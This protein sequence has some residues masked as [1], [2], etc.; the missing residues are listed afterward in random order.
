MWAQLVCV[1]NF[2]E[3]GFTCVYAWVYGKGLEIQAEHEK[4]VRRQMIQI[5]PNQ[6]IN[7]NR[8]TLYSTFSFRIVHKITCWLADMKHIN[9]EL[10]WVRMNI[11]WKAKIN[12][13][14]SLLCAKTFDCS[15]LFIELNAQFATQLL[16]PQSR[17]LNLLLIFH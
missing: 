5:E 3:Q 4:K 2:N 12:S 1:Q 11:F 17:W 9:L 14:V 13:S 8:N 15:S 10:I 7:Q 6:V 16:S